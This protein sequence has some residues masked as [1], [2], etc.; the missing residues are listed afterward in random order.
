MRDWH[1]KESHDIEIML[2]QVGRRA[3]RSSPYTMGARG[4]PLHPISASV[5]T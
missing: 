2:E 5:T 1:V 4:S 3:G